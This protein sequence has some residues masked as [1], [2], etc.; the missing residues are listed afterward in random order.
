[1]GAVQRTRSVLEGLFRSRKPSVRA[2][3]TELTSLRPQGAEAYELHPPQIPSGTPHYDYA[4]LVLVGVPNP[5]ACAST[6]VPLK[7]A[8][9]WRAQL[10]AAAAVYFGR[11]VSYEFAAR[12]ALDEEWKRLVDGNSAQI[13]SSIAIAAAVSSAGMTSDPS[14]G[15]RFGTAPK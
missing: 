14:T 2:V 6:G 3:L 11:P 10:R 9:G 7:T 13:P 12:Y 5:E 1:M 4:L 15:N 8:E